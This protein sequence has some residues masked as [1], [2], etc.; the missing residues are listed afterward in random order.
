MW[1]PSHSPRITGYYVT[2]EEAGGLPRELT[3]RPHAGMSFATIDG[4]WAN[5]KG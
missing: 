3:P 2:Y 1:E 5:E 4:E